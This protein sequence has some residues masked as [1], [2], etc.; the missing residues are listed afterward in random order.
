M[1][2]RIFRHFLQWRRTKNERSL[3]DRPGLVHCLKRINFIDENQSV[4]LICFA[5]SQMNGLHLRSKKAAKLIRG[6]RLLGH[7]F[8][9]FRVAQNIKPQRHLRWK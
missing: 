3:F 1:I 9:I 4:V 5:C 6:L 7:L 2:R 8:L